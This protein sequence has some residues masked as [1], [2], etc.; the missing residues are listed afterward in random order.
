MITFKVGTTN[1]MKNQF[2]HI[3]SLWL[4]KS[5]LLAQKQNARCVPASYCSPLW[6]VVMVTD[7]LALQKELVKRLPHDKCARKQEREKYQI[8]SLV[9]GSLINTNVWLC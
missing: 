7:D 1:D 4:G 3:L 8:Y 5:I 6:T 2:D 9:K